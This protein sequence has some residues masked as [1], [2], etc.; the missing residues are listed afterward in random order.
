MIN[1][2]GYATA[3]WLYRKR[4]HA[5]TRG[6]KSRSFDTLSSS[7]MY[8][9][10]A[11]YRGDNARHRIVPPRRSSAKVNA[12]FKVSFLCAS[13]PPRFPHRTINQIWR[14]RTSLESLF[15]HRQTRANSIRIV[16]NP[17]TIVEC[18]QIES[19][20]A[21]SLGIWQ[22]NIQYT[23]WTT[24]HRI[25]GPFYFATRTRGLFS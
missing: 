18:Q 6:A 2:G 9:L 1:G 20:G 22:V 8:E 11:R 15:N 25:R 16:E 4:S 7:K 12:M 3:A 14:A 23:E 10:P 24:K 5:E 21:C 17:L 19:I 13:L